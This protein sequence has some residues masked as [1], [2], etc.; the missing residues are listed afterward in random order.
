MPIPLPDQKYELR[1]RCHE[2][3][4]SLSA[5]LR[6]QA[7][8]TICSLLESWPFFQQAGTILS[9][10]PI[11]SEVDLTSLLESYPQKR[12]A[13]PRILP[14]EGHRMLFHPYDPQ[15]LVRHPFGMDE[16]SADLPAISPQDIRA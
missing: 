11:K 6:M 9:Y 16:P 3:R 2:I 15:R 1:K 14:G 13:L 12:W 7:S 4:R 8:Q 10:M 5:E